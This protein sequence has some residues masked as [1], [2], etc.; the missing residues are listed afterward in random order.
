M[1]HS[2]SQPIG[3]VPN[4]V[5]FG[6]L[7]LAAGIAPS[8]SWPPGGDPLLDRRVAVAAAAAGC[9]LAGIVPP[10]INALMTPAFGGFAPVMQAALPQPTRDPARCAEAIAFASTLKA[11]DITDL[12]VA[13]GQVPSALVAQLRRHGDMVQWQV[14][15]ADGRPVTAIFRR[16]DGMTDDGS[17]LLQSE[18]NDGHRQDSTQFVRMHEALV[19]PKRPQRLSDDAERVNRSMQNRASQ[20]EDTRLAVACEDGLSHSSPATLAMFQAYHAYQAYQAA[21]Q[22]QRMERVQAW[23]NACPSDPSQGLSQDGREFAQV[24]AGTFG[25]QGADAMDN[26]QRNLPRGG[27]VHP[28]MS[29]RGHE[30]TGPDVE[31]SQDERDLASDTSSLGGDNQMFFDDGGS[32]A[33]LV[34]RLGRLRSTDTGPTMSDSGTQTDPV[35]PISSKAGSEPKPEPTRE[36]GPLGPQRRS[37]PD[38]PV[39]ADE[40]VPSRQPIAPAQ[41]LPRDVADLRGASKDVFRDPRFKGMTGEQVDKE[42]QSRLDKLKEHPNQAGMTAKEK[43]ADLHARLQALTGRVTDAGLRARLEAIQ[44]FNRNRAGSK[45]PVMRRSRSEPVMPTP[46]PPSSDA[47]TQL[48]SRLARARRAA[49]TPGLL[50]GAV[51]DLELARRAPSAS[52][53]RLVAALEARV[54]SLFDALVAPRPSI[55]ARLASNISGKA[56]VDVQQQ[57]MTALQPLMTQMRAAYGAAHDGSVPSEAEA[58]VVR[59]LHDAFR[60]AAGKY[61]QS[62]LRAME[63]RIQGGQGAFGHAEAHAA[64]QRDLAVQLAT[65]EGGRPQQMRAKLLEEAGLLTYVLSGVRSAVTLARQGVKPPASPPAA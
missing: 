53:D 31:V 34:A 35:S 38:R 26:F 65:A 55:G 39:S 14:P 60:R 22:A 12:I 52:L 16:L 23:I 11:K 63:T 6:Q 42:L 64:Q 24:L 5:P 13:E 41:R 51:S 30:R 54:P 56:K 47:P 61:P 17:W 10:F 15:G 44:E 7:P 4:R 48:E 1:F 49:E 46:R 25:P 28:P 8:Q 18:V 36:P 21:D 27:P 9:W 40:P 43:D 29:T 50:R 45:Q 37:L 3:V 20:G 58:F 33:S 2:Y 62:K 32:D 57:L 19:D 59:A